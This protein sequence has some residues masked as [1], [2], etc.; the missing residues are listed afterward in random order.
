MEFIGQG[1]LLPLLCGPVAILTYP[2]L[3]LPVVDRGQY[4]YPDLPAS[5]QSQTQQITIE[6][7]LIWTLLTEL[8]LTSAITATVARLLD[9]NKQAGLQSTCTS[10]NH[11]HP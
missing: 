5:M 8:A 7:L 11:G 10:V 9:H 1:H 4:G 3:A 6:A 2:L